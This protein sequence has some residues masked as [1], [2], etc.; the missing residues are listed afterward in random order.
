[1][2]LTRPLRSSTRA[3]ITRASQG[4]FPATAMARL[5]ALV[6]ETDAGAAE[7]SPRKRLL[8]ALVSL[9]R[10]ELFSEDPASADACA[11]YPSSVMGTIPLVPD[12]EK[13][14]SQRR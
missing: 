6:A 8:D 12:P 9:T 7:P 4:E 2:S 10:P 14:P 13:S 11:W 5:E 3:Q 1:M